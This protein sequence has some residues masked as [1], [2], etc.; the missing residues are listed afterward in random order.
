[1][2][3]YTKEELEE[4]LELHKRWV[5][6]EGGGGQRADL[7]GANLTDANLTGANLA[8]ADLSGAD[9]TDADL[10]DADLRGSNLSGANLY[11][12]NVYRA[13]LAD[14]S[15]S[16]ANLSE[17]D[18]SWANLAGLDL[19][20]AD[21]KPIVDDFY[22]VLSRAKAESVGL[23]DAL[24]KGLVDGSTYSGECACLVGTIANIRHESVESLGINLRANAHRPIERW[25]LAI[26]KG[27]TPSNNP[28]SA[29]TVSWLK[30]WAEKEGIKLPEYDGRSG[31]IKNDKL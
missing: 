16:G 1:M 8:G 12:A 7:S 13:D 21:L 26:K 2:K 11:M 29:I 10:T 22:D 27:D 24:M 9:L 4:I 15:L 31:E 25:F 19:N 18:L 5:S 30:A 14:A 23:Y 20:K 17:A 3:T 28:I 6:S